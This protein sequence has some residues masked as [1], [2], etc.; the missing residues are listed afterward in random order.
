VGCSVWYQKEAQIKFW[1]YQNLMT[2]TG[3]LFLAVAL[4]VA[5][6]IYRMK[7][8]HENEL[9][10]ARALESVKPTRSPRNYYERK[11]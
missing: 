10:R 7:K 11:W 5:Y 1:L 4:L 3:Y 2:I 6:A 9:A 8:K